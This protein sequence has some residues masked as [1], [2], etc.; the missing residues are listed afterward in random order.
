MQALAVLAG[1]QASIC[2][3]GALD[4]LSVDAVQPTFDEVV[5]QCPGNVVVDLGRVTL[6]DSFGV[7][8]IVWLFKRINAEGAHMRVVRA[9]DQPLVVLKLLK[10]DVAFGCC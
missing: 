9:H 1:P 5:A 4:A 10:L 8:A 2:I 6:L 3:E 7:G